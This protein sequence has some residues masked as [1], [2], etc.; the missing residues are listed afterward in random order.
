MARHGFARLL[1]LLLWLRHECNSV[2]S[3]VLN[4]PFYAMHSFNMCFIRGTTR[5]PC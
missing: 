3:F 4:K 1:L 2:N 5:L